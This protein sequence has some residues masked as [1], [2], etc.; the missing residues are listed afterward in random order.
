MQEKLGD[1][2]RNFEWEIFFFENGGWSSL[3]GFENE[4]DAREYFE[5]VVK[6]S[7]LPRDF[8][9]IIGPHDTVMPEAPASCKD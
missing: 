7:S 4:K 6:T 2:G 5:A 3:E 8:Y 9:A 1:E